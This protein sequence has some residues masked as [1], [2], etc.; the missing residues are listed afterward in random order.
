MRVVLG[1][2]D[3]ASYPA[4]SEPVVHEPGKR[5]TTIDVDE[6]AYNLA[7]AFRVITDPGGVWA[8]HS[9]GPGT[10]HDEQATPA[11]V[12]SDNPQLAD[13]LAAH[14]DCPVRNLED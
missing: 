9:T 8:A 7:A 1:N 6:D 10:G 11:W 13:L 14:F 5:A 2:R 4:D 12:A 3:A